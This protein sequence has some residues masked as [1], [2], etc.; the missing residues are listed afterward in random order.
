MRLVGTPEFIDVLVVVT[1]SDD[2]H[3]LIAG[4]QCRYEG[5]F[6]SGHVLR[7]V[8]NEHCLADLVGLDLSLLN[9]FRSAGDDIL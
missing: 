4:H 2:A 1:Y 6:V 8:D 3:L 9:H 5:I 7:F